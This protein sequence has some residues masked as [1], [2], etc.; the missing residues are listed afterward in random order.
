[1]RSFETMNRRGLLAGIGA[2]ALVCAGV[3]GARRAMA[4]DAALSAE[5]M[6]DG[7]TLFTGAGCNVLTMPDRGG[8]M[9]VDGGSRE[10]GAALLDFVAER[11]GGAP[12]NTLFNTNWRNTGA[13]DILGAR[14]ATIVAHKNTAMWMGAEY[15][16]DWEN[17]RYAPRDP[18]ARPNQTF[19][20]SGATS[21]DGARV[22]YAY[23]LQS[24][25]DGDIYVFHRDADVMMAGGVAAD[26]ALGYPVLDYCTGGWIGGMLDG[27]QDMME[28]GGADTLY[29]PA[30]GRVLT[31]ADLQAQYD[32]LLTLKARFIDLMKQGMGAEDMLAAGATAE[33]DETW[34]DPELFVHTAWRGMLGHLRVLGGIIA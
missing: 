10:H 33:Y 19:Y 31:R 23:M 17:R 13:N 30:Q 11:T 26:P 9:M 18:A 14:G 32:M 12:V 2:S 5:D 6:G 24:H 27:L 4:A 15:G 7:L 29:V 8:L 20:E 34:G 21:A 16:V 1:M 22:D 25:T 28:A 3:P